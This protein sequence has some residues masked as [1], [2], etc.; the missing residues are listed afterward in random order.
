MKAGGMCQQKE[1][2]DVKEKVTKGGK[3]IKGGEKCICSMS[4]SMI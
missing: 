3:K 2:I 1:N 4:Q